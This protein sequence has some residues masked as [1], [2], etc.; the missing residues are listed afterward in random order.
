MNQTITAKRIALFGSTGSIGT[1]ALEVIEA[2]PDKFSVEVLT[3]NDNDDLI[4][5]R[6][7]QY[8]YT[9][10]TMS[11]WQIEREQPSK[12]RLTR[13][14]ELLKDGKRLKELSEK[15]AHCEDRLC[16]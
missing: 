7:I 9:K 8:L 12:Q 11:S 1:Q 4:I 3:C 2:N 6:A 5:Q 15:A 13:F 16:K 10:E 14:I